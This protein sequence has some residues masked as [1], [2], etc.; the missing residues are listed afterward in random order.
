MNNPENEYGLSLWQMVWIWHHAFEAFLRSVLQGMICLQI[1]ISCGIFQRPVSRWS[2]HR[3]WV[4]VLLW[5]SFTE[6][7]LWPQGR[8]DAFV[9]RQAAT[10]HTFKW[11]SRRTSCHKSVR[12]NAWAMMARLIAEKFAAI[13]QAQPEVLNGEE[14]PVDE[15]VA[16]PTSTIAAAAA[17]H[18][19][20]SAKL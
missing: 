14:D 8:T 17:D 16:L 9:H 6:Q 10:F 5:W 19:Q 7:G 20:L 11:L 12:W 13:E 1:R 3:V 2:K 4:S 18:S 15:V